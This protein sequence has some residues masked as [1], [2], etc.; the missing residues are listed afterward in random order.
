TVLLEYT[1]GE[2]HSLLFAVTAEQAAAFVLPPASMLQRLVGELRDA[3]LSRQPEYPHGH[4]LHQALLAPAADLIADRDLLVVPDGALHYLP[5]ALLLTQPAA[6]RAV[7]EL[8]YLVRDRAVSVMPSATV[9]GLLAGQARSGRRFG[10]LLAAYGDTVQTG[11]GAAAR[12]PD[13]ATEGWM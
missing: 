6:G 4:E 12:L 3:V 5:F 1:L 2:P 13:T 8:P 10:G 7:A 11:P 9:A